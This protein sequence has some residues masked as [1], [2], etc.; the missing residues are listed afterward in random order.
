[1]KAI[2][3]YNRNLNDAD[4][5]DWKTKQCIHFN[6]TTSIVQTCTV[7]NTLVP[8]S[9]CHSLTLISNPE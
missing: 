1:M 8:Q 7:L 9:T 6:K 3:F 5:F 2:Y 4:T